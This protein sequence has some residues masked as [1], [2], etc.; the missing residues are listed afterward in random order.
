MGNFVKGPFFRIG[1]HIHSLSRSLDSSFQCVARRI[2]AFLHH[3][4]SLESI[5]DMTAM[6]V[7]FR[8]DDDDQEGEDKR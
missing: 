7:A 4:Q 6:I 1:S 2:H 3:P 8:A 5:E